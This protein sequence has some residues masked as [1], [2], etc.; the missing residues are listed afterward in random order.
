MLPCLGLALYHHGRDIPA[1]VV[2]FGITALAGLILAGRQVNYQDI[3][4]REGFAVAALGWFLTA[5]FGSL[6]FVL[7]GAIPH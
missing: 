7:S 5:V 4:Y 1:L 6:P 3:G 2:S